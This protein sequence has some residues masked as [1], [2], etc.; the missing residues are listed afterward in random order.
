MR[1]RIESGQRVTLVPVEPADVHVDDIVLVEWKRSYLLHLVK[2]LTATEV[3]IGNNLGKL[4][5]WVLRQ[6]II[7]KVFQ[8]HLDVTNGSQPAG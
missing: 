4:N 2:E 5:G 8:L 3:L 6:A 7:A 1:G